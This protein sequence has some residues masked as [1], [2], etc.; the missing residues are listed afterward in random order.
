MSFTLGSYSGGRVSVVGIGIIYRSIK[1]D[2]LKVTHPRDVVA[3]N[4]DG[5]FCSSNKNFLGTMG[6]NIFGSRYQ[7]WGEIEHVSWLPK[8]WHEKRS[9]AE[10]LYL[11]SPFYNNISE[12]GREDGIQGAYI[13]EELPDDFRKHAFKWEAGVY[14]RRLR[15][16]ELYRPALK[17]DVEM[18][19]Q[20]HLQP[21][22]A[23]I[24]YRV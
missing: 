14:V 21:V 7:I 8:D 5:V 4:K 12:K 24:G 3:Q 19:N 15:G 6:A 20:N 23:G 16:Q 10:Q 18:G 13:R 2:I 9:R 22:A 1:L 11:R 17:V